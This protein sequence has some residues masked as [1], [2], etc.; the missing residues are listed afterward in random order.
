MEPIITSS[1]ESGETAEQVYEK[2][3]PLLREAYN[4]TWAEEVG[5]K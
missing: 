1:V 3:E 2:L 5:I 4:K